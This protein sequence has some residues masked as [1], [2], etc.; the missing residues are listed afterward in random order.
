[1]CITLLVNNRTAM[2][3]R[4]MRQPIG[5]PMDS[6]KGQFHPFEAVQLAFRYEHTFRQSMPASQVTAMMLSRLIAGASFGIESIA[7]LRAGPDIREG[8]LVPFRT[9]Q[10]HRQV[11]FQFIPGR[12]KNNMDD[13]K[14]IRL[15]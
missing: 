4:D 13:R 11:V 9:S 8:A 7:G 2:I 10:Q 1:M 12:H 5:L 3:K 6:R 15:N 14:S